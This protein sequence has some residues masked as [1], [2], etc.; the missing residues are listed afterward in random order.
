M[1]SDEPTAL[2]PLPPHAPTAQASDLVSA[3][4]SYHNR[5]IITLKGVLQGLLPAPGPGAEPA[6]MLV[7]V[8]REG[9]EIMYGNSFVCKALG[10]L[11]KALDLRTKSE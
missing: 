4:T 9:H 10:V 2:P 3:R 5:T 11:N 1:L 6:T 7:L 8:S